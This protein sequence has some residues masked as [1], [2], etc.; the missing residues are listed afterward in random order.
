MIAKRP[1]STNG[2]TVKSKKCSPLSEWIFLNLNLSTFKME[3][4]LYFTQKNLLF[5][6]M[7]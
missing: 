4:L 6:E 3:V 2:G 1:A 5:I 7:K